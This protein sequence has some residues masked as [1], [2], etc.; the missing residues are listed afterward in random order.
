M[1]SSRLGFIAFALLLLVSTQA[2]AVP[3]SYTGTLTGSDIT[4]T[5]VWVDKYMLPAGEQSSWTA[6]SLTWIITQNADLTWHYDYTLSVYKKDISHFTV[7]VSDKPGYEFEKSNVLAASWPMDKIEVQDYDSDIG[8]S[9][10]GMPSRFRGL[11]FDSTVGTTYHVWFDTDRRPVWGDFYA[12]DGKTNGIDNAIWN[13]GFG[14][15]DTDPSGPAS[16][17]SIDGHLLVPDTEGVEKPPVPEPAG[18]M[19]LG[20]GLMGLGAFLMK[21]RR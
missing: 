11:K 3:V 21:R 7:E 20:S 13:A 1:L 12:K 2:S 8:N 10:P 15:P 16:D 4:G 6:P 5:G 18:M 14:N 9:N 17:G 19:A